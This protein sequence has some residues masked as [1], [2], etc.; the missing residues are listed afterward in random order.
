ME[1]LKQFDH[2]NNISRTLPLLSWRQ[3]Y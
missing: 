3:R 2:E 1:F